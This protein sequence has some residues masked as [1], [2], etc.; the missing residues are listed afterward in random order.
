MKADERRAR[1]LV[2]ERSG[3]ICEVCSAARAQHWHHRLDRSLGGKWQASNGI[4]ACPPCHLHVTSPYGERREVCRRNGWVLE[5][6]ETPA[7]VPVLI[8]H[9]YIFDWYLLDD[10][11]GLVPVE[12]SAA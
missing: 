9:G 8:R 7:L 3:S 6:H 2:Y 10:E 1:D 11:G 4:H 12:R 5:T